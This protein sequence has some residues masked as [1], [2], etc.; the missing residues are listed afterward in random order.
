MRCHQADRSQAFRS[1]QILR[2]SLL[3]VI[4]RKMKLRTQGG[5][6]GWPIGHHNFA[7]YLDSTCWRE[8]KDVISE[9]PVTQKLIESMDDSTGN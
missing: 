5:F 6:Q 3:A 2:N 4:F 1:R 8:S 9:L 7:S